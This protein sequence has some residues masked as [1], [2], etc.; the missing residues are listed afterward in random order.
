[1]KASSATGPDD[2]PAHLY[3]DY[4]KELAYPLVKIWRNTLDSRKMPEG[5]A[6]A[7]KKNNI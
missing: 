4:G 1:M 3:K 6:I 2:I 7:I 5:I